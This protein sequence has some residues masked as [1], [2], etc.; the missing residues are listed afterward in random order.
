MLPGL[1]AAHASEN[2]EAPDF[3]RGAEDD[4]DGE[5]EAVPDAGRFGTSSS[6]LC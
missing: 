4:G 6:S 1:L 2:E 3:G 5:E